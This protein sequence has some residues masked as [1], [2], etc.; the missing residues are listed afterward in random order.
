MKTHPRLLS[1]L[2]LVGFPLL[3]SA[4]QKEPAQSTAPAP[5]EAPAADNAAVNTEVTLETLDQRVSYAVGRNFGNQIRNDQL[6]DVDANAVIAG[7]R[8]ALSSAEAKMTDD[9]INQAFTEIRARAQEAQMAGW[10]R[11]GGHG[12][13]PM[14]A[15]WDPN[16]V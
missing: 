4:C 15:D 9:E 14:T 10:G 1:C 13:T 2:L 6:V 16:L 5:A 11:D 3:F 8:D 12:D 7:L